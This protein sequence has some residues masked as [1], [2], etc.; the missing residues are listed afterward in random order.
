[1]AAKSR[2]RTVTVSPAV[3]LSL[4]EIWLWNAN[5]YGSRHADGYLK[6]IDSAMESLSLPE[7]TGRPI[8]NRPDLNYLLIRR[9][10]GGHGHVAVFQM[11]G[12]QVVVLR[13]FHT[14]Q[15]W[16]TGMSDPPST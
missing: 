7:N 10:Q 1:M 11:Q 6:F 14:A 12:D 4:R 13:L 3:L 9:R 15:D 2:R 8:V 5:R 16:L